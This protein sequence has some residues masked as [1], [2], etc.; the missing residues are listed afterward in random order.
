MMSSRRD[1]LSGPTTIL[2]LCGSKLM[3]SFPRQC[4]CAHGRVR[5]GRC[6]KPVLDRG[7]PSGTRHVSCNF[8]Y[9]VPFV[10]C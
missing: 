6:K 4:V 8:L 10:K 2:H 5:T 9:K 3:D 1:F 7:A